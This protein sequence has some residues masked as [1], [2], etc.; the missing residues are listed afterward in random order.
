MEHLIDAIA[1]NKAGNDAKLKIDTTGQPRPFNWRTLER[2]RQD[3]AD[4]EALLGWLN[5]SLSDK[6]AYT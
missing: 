1:L 4:F 6:R 2:V 5:R 3:N